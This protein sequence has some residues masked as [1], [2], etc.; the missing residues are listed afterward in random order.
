MLKNTVTGSVLAK[1]LPSFAKTFLE[2]ASQD[3]VNQAEQE[4]AVLHQKLQAGTGTPTDQEQAAPGA[5]PIVPVAAT[6]STGSQVTPAPAGNATD[7]TSQLTAMT[8]RA[9]T[10]EASVTSLNSQLASANQELSRYKEWYQKQ[11]GVG[12]TLPTADASNRGQA[13]QLDQTLS[14][15]SSGALAAFLK[16]KSQG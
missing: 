11:K 16:R 6:P 12:T 3:E 10:A 14:L 4:A 5:A 1:L 9:T 7:L 2:N 13:A 8:T 15:A